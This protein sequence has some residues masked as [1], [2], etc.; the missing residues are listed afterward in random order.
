M[1]VKGPRAGSFKREK[2]M[3]DAL[4]IALHREAEKGQKTKRLQRVAEALVDRAIKGDVAAT[5]EI[6][7]RV[8]GKK[9]MPRPSDIGLSEEIEWLRNSPSKK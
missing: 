8:D 4:I 2:F 3:R 5:R 7:D 1:R 9:V 6:F